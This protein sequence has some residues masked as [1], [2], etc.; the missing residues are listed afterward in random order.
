[1]AWVGVAS[2]AIHTVGHQGATKARAMVFY[3]NTSG[4]MVDPSRCSISY[5]RKRQRKRE[6][7]QHRLLMVLVLF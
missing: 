7:D 6:T 5:P 3:G 2:A 4:L 1:M